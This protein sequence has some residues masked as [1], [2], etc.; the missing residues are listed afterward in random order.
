M[1]PLPPTESQP[2]EIQIL[3]DLHLELNQQYKTYTFPVTA[4]ILLLAGDTGRLVD[5]DAYLHFIA[6]QT[7]RYEKVLLV[8]G[9]HEFFGAT[10]EEGLN[11]AV[12]LEAEPALQGRLVLLH[13][14]RWECPGLAVLGCT[15]WSHVPD[16]RKDAVVA[17]VG[18]YKRIQGWT[19]D[20]HN[21]LH[22]EDV[23]W[24]REQVAAAGAEKMLV[25]THHAPCVQGTSRPEHIENPWTVAFA[26]DVLPH[27]N[28]GSVQ[29]WVYGHTHYSTDFMCNGVRVVA[30]QRGYVSTDEDETLETSKR[31]PHRF[32]ARMTISL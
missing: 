8:L 29:T 12:K 25:V 13:R 3:S 19:T 2:P 15:L 26:T 28:W 18:D 21:R 23:A 9:N 10:Y 17:K 24:L 7:A 27:G 31:D 16:D 4:P 6:A 14:R 20:L 22:Q 11:A 5:Y 1:K 32:D 30:N